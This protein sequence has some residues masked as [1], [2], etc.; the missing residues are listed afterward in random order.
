MTQT[1]P[2][3]RVRSPL[4]PVAV[5]AALAMCAC[6]KP[7]Q[8]EITRTRVTTVQPRPFKAIVASSERFPSSF[9][10][11]HG[12][13][14]GM[15]SGA[16]K[17]PDTLAPFNW[18]TPAGWSVAKPTSMR[19]VNMKAGSDAECYVT[20]LPGS[21]GGTL[22]NVNRWRDQLGLL[23][24]GGD[25]L[26]KL[27]NRKVLGR[28]AVYVELEDGAGKGI[29]GV[30]LPY[31]FSGTAGTLFVKMVGP[32]ATLSGTEGKHF[33]AFCASLAPASD[34]GGGDHS[35]HNHGKP[36]DDGHGPDDGHDHGPNDGHDHGTSDEPSGPSG[37]PTPGPSLS[38]TTPEG[39][40]QESKARS[41]REVTFVPTAGV[42]C[43]VSILRGAAGGV[44]AN[45]NR[46]RNQV[47]LSPLDAA[48]IAALETVTI[49]GREA[50]VLD[51][52]GTYT[53]M[54]GEK[55]EDTTLVGVVC[56]L[57]DSTLFVKMIGPS[58]AA[59][60]ERDRFLALCGSL[61]EA[62]K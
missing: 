50:R 42:E 41:M 54:G 7:A 60:A 13:A 27:P 11:G 59:T 2:E 17:S 57:D 10:P 6:D 37:P 19:I 28:T 43:Y 51:A 38:W 52:I 47:G 62:S 61:K 49:L 34:H 48:G 4:W 45:V 39:W 26:A 31:S 9:G 18:V 25:E 36:A 16:G 44:E 33:K 21:A 20:H 23:D 29:L 46:W 8:L 3:A 56:E 15:G 35:S 30:I 5:F 40:T 22:A 12:S 53:D 32:W 24:I 58:A 14:G 1:N 55:R